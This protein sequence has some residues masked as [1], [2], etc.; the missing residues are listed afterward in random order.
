MMHISSWKDYV[1]LSSPS[2]H[3]VEN[4]S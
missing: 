1:E 4:A 3:W 2:K